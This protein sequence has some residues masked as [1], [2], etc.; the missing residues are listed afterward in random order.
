MGAV[1]SVLGGIGGLLGG[2]GIGS[3]AKRVART[4]DH[5]AEQVATETRE[6][7]RLIEE[8]VIPALEGSLGKLNET[9]A[10]VDRFVDV[11]TH[12][13]NVH[14]NTIGIVVMILAAVLCR[15]LIHDIKASPL[16]SLILYTIYYACLL[17]VFFFG[18]E[19]L[20]QLG[21]LSSGGSY[22][23]RLVVIIFGSAMFEMISEAFWYVV[24]HVT[25]LLGMLLH[26]LSVVTEFIL[27]KPFVWFATPVTRGKKYFGTTCGLAFLVYMAILVAYYVEVFAEL[28]S[29]A[30]ATWRE[31]SGRPQA[32][33]SGP[34]L[35]MKF[36]I[37]LIL[38]VACTAASL[39]THALSSCIIS[40]VFRRYWRF[41]Q[42]QRIK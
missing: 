19:L 23:Y 42:L 31:Y 12:S 32:V 40:Q 37:A 3:A 5:L 15:R 30:V 35:D 20:I 1:G 38:Y 17:L 9:L 34:T 11:A 36:K 18:Y 2:F 21:I 14:T 4:T 28:C 7:R 41:R 26:C 6:I 33:H 8:R 13:L 25:K 16:E 27:V 29:F 22:N 39:L 24:Q 10:H